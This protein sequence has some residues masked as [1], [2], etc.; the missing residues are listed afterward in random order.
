[1]NHSKPRTGIPLIFKRLPWADLFSFAPGRIMSFNPWVKQVN[2]PSGGR[3]RRQNPHRRPPM[4]VLRCH[5]LA[6]YFQNS[7]ASCTMDRMSLAM[8]RVFFTVSSMSLPPFRRRGYLKR[9]VS[10]S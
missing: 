9:P 6:R 10:G 5:A 4:G 3:Q 8:E 2:A 7:K 1:M